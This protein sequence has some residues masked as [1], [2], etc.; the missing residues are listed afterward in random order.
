MRA[1]TRH[2]RFP[3]SQMLLARASSPRA[4]LLSVVL[5][6]EACSSS[7]TTKPSQTAIVADAPAPAAAEVFADGVISDAQEQWRI[8]FTPDGRSAY[9]ASSPEFFPITRKATIYTSRLENGVWSAP[10]VAPFSGKHS[11]ID[12]FITP[13]GKR[14]YFSSIRPVDGAT[15]RDIDIWMVERTIDGS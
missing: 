2:L 5:L 11:D 12:P 10:V 14:L 8:T 15:P 9:F 4:A 7:S 3:E 13:D 6:V 1:E